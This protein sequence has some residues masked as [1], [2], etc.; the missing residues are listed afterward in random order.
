VRDTCRIR[1]GIPGLSDN[2][3]VISIVGKFLEHSRIFYFRNG[4]EEEF[5][6][7]SADLMT[8]NLEHRVEVLTPI[9][10]EIHREECRTILNTCLNDTC[11]AWQMQSDGSYIQR[12]TDDEEV[13]CAQ[14]KMVTLANDRSKSARA[15]KKLNYKSGNRKR[16][17]R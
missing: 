15:H 14:E 16:R 13:I 7:G 5:Y 4:G 8:R 11:S 12:R 2:I 1:P 9:E 10:E 17:N 6:I 3:S